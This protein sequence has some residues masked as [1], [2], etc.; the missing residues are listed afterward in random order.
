MLMFS[1]IDALAVAN[2]ANR[3]WNRIP[4]DRDQC[5]RLNRYHLLLRS[6]PIAHIGDLRS[7]P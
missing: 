3:V 4:A 1:F 5:R 6:C 7:L 2:V